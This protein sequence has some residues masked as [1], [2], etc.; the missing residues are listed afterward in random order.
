[1]RSV[2][3]RIVSLRVAKRRGVVTGSLWR[4]PKA[5]LAGELDD[6]GHVLRRVGQG[7][8]C[9]PLIDGQVPRLAHLVEALMLGDHKLAIECLRRSAGPEVG[10]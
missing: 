2:L 10:G 4:H 9:R 1:M 8:R 5:L 6:R 7:H 3:S